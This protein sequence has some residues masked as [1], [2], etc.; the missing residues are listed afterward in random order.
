[1]R[2]QMGRKSFPMQLA[3]KPHFVYIRVNFESN[4]NYEMRNKRCRRFRTNF[5]ISKRRNKLKARARERDRE[6]E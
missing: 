2:R 5:H 1:M 6:G 4:E 3:Q